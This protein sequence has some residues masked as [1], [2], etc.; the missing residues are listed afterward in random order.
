MQMSGSW[1][2]KKQCLERIFGIVSSL[3]EADKSENKDMIRKII[4]L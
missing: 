2:S 4:I 1:A 3:P